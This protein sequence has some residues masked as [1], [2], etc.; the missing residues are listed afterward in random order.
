VHFKGAEAE[1]RGADGGF[2]GWRQSGVSSL[3]FQLGGR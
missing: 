3:Q 2:D 1:R